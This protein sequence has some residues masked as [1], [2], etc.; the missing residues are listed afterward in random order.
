[1][2]C[3]RR[4][5]MGMCVS[6]ILMPRVVAADSW[7]GGWADS[8]N[9][10]SGNS[11]PGGVFTP[12]RA[13]YTIQRQ[14][15]LEVSFARKELAY[16][17]AGQAVL[18]YKVVTPAQTQFRRGRVTDI[19][20]RPTWTPGN[21]GM[22]L[23]RAKGGTS[24]MLVNGSVPYGH[25]LNPMGN[26]KFAISGFGAVRIHGTQ[27]YDYDYTDVETLG[28]VRLMNGSPGI[29]ELVSLLGPNGIQEG[30]DVVFF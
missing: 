10:P 16:Y 12:T 2:N 23:F 17:R 18:G 22:R 14:H 27:S 29:D 11:V 13:A 25:P 8:S 1:M 20:G 3:S 4:S 5:A 26:Y 9:S 15:H 28:C 21:A 19:I 30:I 6:S 7:G 24:N